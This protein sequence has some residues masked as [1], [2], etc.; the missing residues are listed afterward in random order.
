LSV[1]VYVNTFFE[2]RVQQLYE[3]ANLIE[4][5]FASAGL[6]YRVVGGLATYLYVEE[7]EPDA[8]RLT[9]DIDIV[10]RRED[11]DKIAKAAEPFGLE[12]RVV[13]GVGRLARVGAAPNRRAINL[14]PAPELGAVQ[15]KKGIRLVPLPELIHMKLTSF[16]LKDQMHLKDLDGVGLITS[17]VQ[18]GL[19][20]CLN[21]RLAEVR[22]REWN[23]KLRGPNAI[24]SSTRMVSFATNGSPYR[25]PI[26]LP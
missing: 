15:T 1:A 21:E 13:A 20:P 8:G 14:W 16:R 24:R 22:A 2:V 11:I 10:V 23:Y 7:A 25:T 19:P 26:R 6:E 3:L 17:E 4:L 9:K 12:Y 18:A 5:I